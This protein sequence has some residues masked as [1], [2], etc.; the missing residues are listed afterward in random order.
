MNKYVEK[1]VIVLKN[2]GYK[3]GIISNILKPHT[4]YSKAKRWFK[5]FSPVI[6][7]CEVGLK[8]PDKRI[9]KLMLEKLR[10]NANECIYIDDRVKFLETAK[11]L[12]MKTIL[13]QNA[14]QLRKELINNGIRLKRWFD[15]KN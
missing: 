13:F 14:N 12:G 2:S 4:K 6:L 15:D 10:L 3:L 5:N 1:I 11:K 8:K 9:Y 7:S